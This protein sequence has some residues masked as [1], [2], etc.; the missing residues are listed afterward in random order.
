[1]KKIFPVAIIALFGVVLYTSCTK[2]EADAAASYVCSCSYPSKLAGEDSVVVRTTFGGLYSHD[3][4]V[5]QCAKYETT[6]QGSYPGSNCS[7]N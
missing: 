6:I 4:A 3:K 2:N 7:V 5:V 1:M